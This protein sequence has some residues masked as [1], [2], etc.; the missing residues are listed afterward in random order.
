MKFALFDDDELDAL[1]KQLKSQ[2]AKHVT[3][4]AG[5]QGGSV[6]FSAR[7]L[8]DICGQLTDVAEEMEGRGILRTGQTFTDEE[9]LVFNRY[10]RFTRL[11]LQS[12][13]GCGS[14]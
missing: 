8:D 1:A 5:G 4:A 13:C 10:S 9:V 14:H 12:C 7:S 11:N 2:Y 6:T 3:S